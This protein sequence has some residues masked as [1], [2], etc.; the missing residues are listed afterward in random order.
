MLAIGTTILEQERAMSLQFARIERL[1]NECA[2][3]DVEIEASLAG[4]GELM[5][6]T[7]THLAQSRQARDRMQLLNFNSMIEARHLGDQA[8]RSA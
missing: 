8:M 1:E 7:K 4:I 3:D 2:A 5:R 6:I